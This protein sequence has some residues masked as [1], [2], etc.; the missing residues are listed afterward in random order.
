MKRTFTLADLADVADVAVA[1]KKAVAPRVRFDVDSASFERA[2]E[3]AIKTLDHGSERVV[4]KTMVFMAPVKPYGPTPEDVAELEAMSALLDDDSIDAPNPVLWEEPLPMGVWGAR[5]MPYMNGQDEALAA[6]ASILR[7]MPS[8]L[9]PQ[10]DPF[11][12]PEP[13]PPGWATTF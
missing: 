2:S 4:R 12:L 1:P 13:L 10:A 8:A 9:D 11:P 5:F 3:G 6:I 7:S